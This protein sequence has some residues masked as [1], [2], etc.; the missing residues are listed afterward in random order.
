MKKYYSKTTTGF[1]S[2]EIHGDAI[3]ADAVE[4]STEKYFELRDGRAQ[5]K[6]ISSDVDGLLVLVDPPPIDPQIV[7]SAILAPVKL[8]REVAINRINGIADRK[9]RAGN[10]TIREIGDDAVEALIAMTKNMPT[11]PALI[12]DTIA[13]RYAAIVEPLIESAPDLLSAFSDIDQ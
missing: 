9:Q 1:Y 11:D 4:I 10:T 13:A 3:P 12:E 5:G 6:S 8:L 7:I 2:S